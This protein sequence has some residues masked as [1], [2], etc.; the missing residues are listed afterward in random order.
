MVAG[1]TYAITLRT[2]SNLQ[3]TANSLYAAGAHYRTAGT[4][5][6]ASDNGSDL[7]FRTYV[8][9]GLTGTSEDLELKFRITQDI[10][11][12]RQ[13]LENQWT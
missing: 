8:V 12:C 5:W 10:K 2:N 6:P 4:T 11:P 9:S 7:M 1:L 13:T 3:I